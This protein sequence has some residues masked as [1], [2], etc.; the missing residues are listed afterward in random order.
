MITWLFLLLVWLHNETLFT[1]CLHAGGPWSIKALHVG[2][3]VQQDCR[4]SLA[5]P[6]PRLLVLRFIRM[7]PRLNWTIALACVQTKL[8]GKVHLGTTGRT[9]P[10]D[11]R[12]FTRADVAADEF[13][14][15]KAGTLILFLELA[16]EEVVSKS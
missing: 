9:L 2:E 4:G 7:S 14:I 5:A 15:G 13:E 8:Q 10:D 12:S 3:A 16:L 1:P 6:T 11:I